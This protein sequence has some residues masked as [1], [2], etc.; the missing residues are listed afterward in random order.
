[1][2]DEELLQ[3]AVECARNFQDFP[4]VLMAISL[5]P[6]WL[7]IIPENRKW[8]ILHQIIFSGDVNQL[9]QLL[10]LQK[11]NK[12]FRLQTNTRQQETVLDIAALR[13]DVPDMLKR[14]Q[15]L[16]KL[17]EMLTYARDC[18]WDKCYNIIKENPSFVNEKPPYRRFYLIHH[19][20]Y[21]NAIKAYETIKQIKGCKFDLNLR[22]D[23]K[24]I[25]LIAKEGQQF[26]FA[27]YIEKECPSLLEQDDPD[28]DS[29]YH[30][31]DH[32]I[33]Q[34]EIINTMMEQTN[35]IQ[36]LDQN[37]IGSGPTKKSRDEVMKYL[38][39]SKTNTEIQEV[40][41]KVASTKIEENKHKEILLDNLTCP[42]TLA[43]FTDPV[44]AADGFT[45]ERSA[46]TKWL[47]KNDRSPMTNQ[48]LANKNLNPNHIVK[49]IISAFQTV[50]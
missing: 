21:A 7:T 40:Q 29:I 39:N 49:Q 30:A 15:Q 11:L 27:T 17:D 22:A 24:K 47:E 20:A 36:D 33:K 35:I 1:M 3:K 28:D 41:T 13:K 44:I 6:E 14:I 43:V 37:L 31:T 46:I 50:L 9:E 4:Q 48:K 18:Q 12:K 26:A 45:Y 23:R 25:N 8:A 34:T 19:I 32:A 5:H 38:N 2:S 42:L 10:A 16:I